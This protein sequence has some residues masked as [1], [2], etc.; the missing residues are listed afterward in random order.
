MWLTNNT[1]PEFYQE[2]GILWPFSVQLLQSSFL[3]WKFIINLTNVH[4]LQQSVAVGV[5]CLTDMYE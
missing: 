1:H 5:I 3:L 2:E 4:R